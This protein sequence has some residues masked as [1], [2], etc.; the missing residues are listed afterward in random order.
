[1]KRLLGIAVAVLALAA[2]GQSP[3]QRRVVKDVLDYFHSRSN[4]QQLFRE[5]SVEGAVERVSA[6]EARGP[7]CRVAVE[8][9]GARG[10]LPASGGTGVAWCHCRGCRAPRVSGGLAQWCLL[11]RRGAQLLINRTV[12]GLNSAWCPAVPWQDMASRS[13]PLPSRQLRAAGW[14]FTEGWEPHCGAQGYFLGLGSLL[15][16]GVPLFLL[17]VLLAHWGRVWCHLI[18]AHPKALQQLLTPWA[19]Q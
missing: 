15:G 14:V 17:L 9:C 19:P 12:V 8:L 5:Q 13:C 16:A 1:M 7:S 11:A 6:G 3:L 2:A 10:E 18:L 4:V